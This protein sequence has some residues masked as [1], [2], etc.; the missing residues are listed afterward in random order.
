MKKRLD[1]RAYSDSIRKP[2]SISL[3]FVQEKTL[4]M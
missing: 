2:T 1:T 4:L 3:F